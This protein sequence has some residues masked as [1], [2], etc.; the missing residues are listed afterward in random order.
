MKTILSADPSSTTSQ[1]LSLFRFYIVC[2][3]VIQAL[4]QAKNVLVK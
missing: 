3:D 2:L 4:W 1:Y